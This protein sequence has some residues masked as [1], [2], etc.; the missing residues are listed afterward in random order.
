MHIS[1][2]SAII[3]RIAEGFED[4]VLECMH[5]NYFQ[6]TQAVREQLWSGLDGD[7]NHLSP[8]YDNDP[9]FNSRKWHHEED[10][11]TY[12][13]REGYKEWKYDISP[14]S[15]SVLLDLPPRPLEVPNLWIDG[16]FYN[17]IRSR[18]TTDG[19]DVDA[20]GGNGP[21]ITQKYGI[22]IYNLTDEAKEWFNRTFLLPYIGEFFKKCGY[23]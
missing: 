19:V 6:F 16:T 3:K 10:G 13:G 2:V 12:V 18:A 4:A 21:K 5:Q 14:P 17:S 7:G 9:Y 23:V 15:S 8:T 22:Q 11:K 20:Y 1:K